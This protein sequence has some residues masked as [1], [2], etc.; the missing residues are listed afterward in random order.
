MKSA[1]ELIV[2]AAAGHLLQRERRHPERLGVARP[3][4]LAEQEPNREVGGELRRPPETAVGLVE[5]ALV[6]ADGLA[7]EAGAGGL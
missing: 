4:V 6:G 2:H 3:P 5:D 7:D 1:G